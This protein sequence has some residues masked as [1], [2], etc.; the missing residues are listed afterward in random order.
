M[1]YSQDAD[2]VRS[3]NARARA[4]RQNRTLEDLA[5]EYVLACNVNHD[6]A[7]TLAKLEYK[8]RKDYFD[9]VKNEPN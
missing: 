8:M 2:Y 6:D 7:M 3:Q 1:K 4:K 9:S 5:N